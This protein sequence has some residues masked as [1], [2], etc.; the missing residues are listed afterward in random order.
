[1]PKA[2]P[3]TKAKKIEIPTKQPS[4]TEREALLASLQ[5]R[6]EKNMHRHKGMKWDVVAKKLEKNP[7]ALKALH[8]MVLTGGEPDVV[9]IGS[10]TDILFVDCSVQTPSGRRSTCYDEKARKERKKFPPQTSAMEVAKQMGVEMLN[11]EQY[12]K[13]QTL[14]EFDTTTS[15]WILTPTEVRKLGGALFCDR[16]YETVF[17]YHNGA[18]SYYGARGFRGMVKI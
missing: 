11:E 6:F 8:A 13:L 14:D 2:A 17:T 12:R 10:K 15:S 1:M 18:D 16:R 5:E 4:A 3:K 9:S 7:K